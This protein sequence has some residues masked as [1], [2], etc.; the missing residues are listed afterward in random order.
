MDESFYKSLLDAM[1][2]GVYFVDGDR[3]ITFWNKAAERIS[4]FAAPE[5]LGKSCADNLLRHVDEQ[6]RELCVEGCPLAAVVQ[7]GSMREAHVYMRHK[8]GHRIPVEVRATAMRD[9][10]GKVVGGVEI[11]RTTPRR[12]NIREEIEKLRKEV[13]TDPLTGVGNRRYAQIRLRECEKDFRKYGVP[14]GVLFLDIDHFKA[15]NDTWGHGVG[16]KVLCMVAGVLDRCLRNLDAACRWGGEEFLILCRNITAEGLETLAERLRM[17]IEKSWLDHQGRQIRVTASLG[18]A[19]SRREEMADQTV[20][21]ADRQLY[22]SKDEGRNRVS[23]E[24]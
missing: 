15:V 21:R 19:L 16:D 10:S 3:R 13:L 12:S 1:G 17:L 18:G 20:E 4:G 8:S 23:M 6:G 9:G 7:D 2:D 14:Y 22:R 11:F 5:V 24:I